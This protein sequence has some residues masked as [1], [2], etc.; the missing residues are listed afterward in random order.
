MIKQLTPDIRDYELLDTGCGEKLERFG[1]YVVRRPE[2]QAIWRKSLDDREWLRADASF[3]RDSK[4]E[5]RGEW[6]L[7]PEMPSRW[8][9]EYRYKTMQLRMRLALTS[10]KHVGIFPEQ[11]ANWNFI[12]D[13][14]EELREKCGIERPKVL[15]LFAY[16]GGA[17]LAAC[18]AGADTTHVDSVKQVVTWARENME[19]SGLDGVRWIVEDAVKFVEREVRRGNKYHGIILDPPAYGPLP[20][21]SLPPSPG[22]P[23]FS[24][25]QLPWASEAGPLDG[26]Y[27]LPV[28]GT[29]SPAPP[30]LLCAPPSSLGPSQP[31][32]GSLFPV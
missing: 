26:M 27:Y 8:S 7:R 9:V 14:V 6:K 30:F 25:P 3:L 5:E 19:Q 12:Y 22:P 16:T 15:N 18:A 4:S 23:A 24:G 13:S 28:S 29:P 20:G 11:A 32:K 2:P 10:F 31:N 21:L 17:T 1:R